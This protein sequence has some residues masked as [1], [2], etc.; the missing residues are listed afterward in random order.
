MLRP[1]WL[2]F[3]VRGSA[4][5]APSAA[6]SVPPIRHAVQQSPRATLRADDKRLEMAAQQRQ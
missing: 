1:P 2:W 5:G 6:Q 3:A 4:L